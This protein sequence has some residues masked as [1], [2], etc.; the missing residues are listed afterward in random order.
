MSPIFLSFLTGFSVL[1]PAIS[2]GILPAS[3]HGMTRHPSLAVPYATAG[4]LYI[5]FYSLL[6]WASWHFLLPVLPLKFLDLPLLIAA[7]W[8]VSWLIGLA[9]K[10]APEIQ[11]ALPIQLAG[12]L[13]LG[14]CLILI[15]HATGGFPE[16][17]ALAA[18]MSAG[19]WFATI[20][21]SMIR[22]RLSP[23]L[24]FA[25]RGWPSLLILCSLLWLAAQSVGVSLP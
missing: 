14:S 23:Q 17:A 13:V 22:E 9:L 15:D 6:G 21:L 18:G 2:L 3:Y 25:L 4:S 24:P 8:I 11:A 5:L 19:Y 7:F 1:S 12:C 10:K 20:V 16:T